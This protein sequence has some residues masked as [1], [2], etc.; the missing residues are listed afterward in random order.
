MRR[1]LLFLFLALAL[2][3]V[4]ATQALGAPLMK[5]STAHKLG[6]DPGSPSYATWDSW[7]LMS[8]STS[9]AKYYIKRTVKAPGGYDLWVKI[10]NKTPPECSNGSGSRQNGF[11]E[12]P[13]AVLSRE[14]ENNACKRDR[15]RTLA[16]TIMHV[17]FACRTRQAKYLESVDYGQRG[18]PAGS[19]RGKDE[20][21]AVIPDTVMDG[22]LTQMCIG[23]E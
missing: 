18:E 8:E 1:L 2:L 3:N 6:P 10:E 13:F 15:E 7:I 9:G 4:G 14:A 20:W 22:L 17:I 23:N 19:D 21:V 5:K 11:L 12:S 16:S